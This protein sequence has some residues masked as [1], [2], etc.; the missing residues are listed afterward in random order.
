MEFSKQRNIIDKLNK[1][2]Y[3]A[4]DSDYISVSEWANGEG[5]DIDINGKQMIHL[6]V[7]ELEGIYYLTKSIDYNR[8]K[9]E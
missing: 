1:Y 2:D 8:D 5:Y 7:G 3:L 9:Y 4:N 6:S